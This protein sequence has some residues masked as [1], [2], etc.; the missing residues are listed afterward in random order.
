MPK[1]QRDRG[2]TLVELIIVIAIIAVLAVV[3]I[4][5]FGGAQRNSRDARRR[6][7]IKQIQNAAE[8]FFEICLAYPVSPDAFDNMGAGC[9]GVGAGGIG[10][11][12]SD[13]SQFPRDPRATAADGFRG[14]YE[15]ASA[16]TTSYQVC[17][18]LEVDPSGLIDDDWT[19]DMDE[20]D[21]CLTQIQQ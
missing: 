9:T 16:T 7:D 21:F 5:T 13:R 18:D 19:V 17:A 4:S 6:A 12:L 3:A 1:R 20:D 10:Q 8:R 2:F 14:R 15:V 11:Y